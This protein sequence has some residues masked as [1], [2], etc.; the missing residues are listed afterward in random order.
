MNGDSHKVLAASLSS[1]TSE[2]IN[3]RRNFFNESTEEDLKQHNL[4]ALRQ[5]RQR[6]LH[7]DWTQCP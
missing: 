6:Y 2:F 3:V 4:T 1:S 5:L 7:S